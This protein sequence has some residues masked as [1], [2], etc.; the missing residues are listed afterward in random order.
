[1]TP[2]M[3]QI[4]LLE[5]ARRARFAAE[6]DARHQSMYGIIV[7]RGQAVSV[8]RMCEKLAGA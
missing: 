5:N 2:R 7:T 3:Q 1:M 8:K 6:A 4:W